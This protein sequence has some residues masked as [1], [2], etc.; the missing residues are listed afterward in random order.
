MGGW[1]LMGL[2][3]FQ[4]D[5]HVLELVAMVAPLCGYIKTIELYPLKE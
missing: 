5:K 3:F 1:L 2:G 4:G